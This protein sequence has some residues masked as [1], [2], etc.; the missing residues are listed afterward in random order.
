MIHASSLGKAAHL[1]RRSERLNK[2]PL[3]M[4]M[5]ESLESLNFIL[6]PEKGTVYM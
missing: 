2:W 4:F 5:L 1:E 3:K 6:F